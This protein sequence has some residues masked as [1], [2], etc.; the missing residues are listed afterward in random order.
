[1]RVKYGGHACR[2]GLDAC[3]AGGFGLADHLGRDGF[4]QVQ[5]HEV[6]DVGLDGAEAVAVLETLLDCGD[7]RD[8]VG[9]QLNQFRFHLLLFIFHSLFG[10][11]WGWSSNVGKLRASYHDIDLVDAALANRRRH[12]LRHLAVPEMDVRIEGCGQREL[13]YLGELH[14]CLGVLVLCCGLVGESCNTF[15]GGL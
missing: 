14:V 3:D 8:Q 9:L 12:E 10:N 1:M 6:V 11:I 7:G 15:H 5:R 13:V 4:V 2:V